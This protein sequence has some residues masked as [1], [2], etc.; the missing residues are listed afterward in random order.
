MNRSY[1][2]M[3]WLALVFFMI[4]CKPKYCE[5]KLSKIS[6]IDVVVEEG[7]VGD[8]VV[9]KKFIPSTTSEIPGIRIYLEAGTIIRI[10]VANERCKLSNSRYG[11]GDLISDLLPNSE[12][13]LQQNESK[14]SWIVGN[15]WNADWGFVWCDETGT[16]RELSVGKIHDHCHWEIVESAGY[17]KL[18]NV[19]FENFLWRKG[20]GVR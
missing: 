3:T 1:L 18:Y 9:G 2:E 12:L 14:N 13:G 19:D 6:R 5:E 16:V 7:R 8:M 10:D 15:F 11:I 17:P 4:A 20:E